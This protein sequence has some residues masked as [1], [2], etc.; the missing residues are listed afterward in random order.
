MY[1]AVYLGSDL[2]AALAGLQV[3][4]LTHVGSVE[5]E[6]VRDVLAGAELGPDWLCLTAPPPGSRPPGPPPPP[7]QE[8]R[9]VEPTAGRPQHPL[10][11]SQP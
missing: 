3:D 11:P 1:G 8:G 7:L 9:T 5:A 6:R 4:D 2:V 10:L